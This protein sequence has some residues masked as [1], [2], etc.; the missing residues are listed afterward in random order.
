MTFVVAP[1]FVVA[2]SPAFHLCIDPTIQPSYLTPLVGVVVLVVQLGPVLL[3][4]AFWVEDEA[5][6][7]PFLVLVATMSMAPVML[8]PSVMIPMAVPL[9]THPCVSVVVAWHC[10]SFWP[11]RPHDRHSCQLDLW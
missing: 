9:N 5:V 4:E 3:G 2:W 1:T 10:M 8:V 11:I 7:L 6:M